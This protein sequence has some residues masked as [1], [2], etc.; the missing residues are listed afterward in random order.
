MNANNLRRTRT[1]LEYLADAV[2]Y[3][4]VDVDVADDADRNCR[5]IDFGWVSSQGKRSTADGERLAAVVEDLREREEF[6]WAVD[7]FGVG[8]FVDIAT[9]ADSTQNAVNLFGHVFAI[10]NLCDE[11]RHQAGTQDAEPDHDGLFAPHID[12]VDARRGNV[13]ATFEDEDTAAEFV[14]LWNTDT[15]RESVAVRSAADP[16]RVTV[17]VDL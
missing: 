13:D 16:N 7:I 8:G 6:E 4:K 10:A 5:I 17:G 9:G 15:R 1:D 3:G 12:A 14:G 11:A 2:H